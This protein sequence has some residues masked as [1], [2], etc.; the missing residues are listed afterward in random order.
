MELFEWNN[1][2]YGLV[3]MS[4]KTT[5]AIGLL[6]MGSLIDK[7]GTKKDFPFR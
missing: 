1:K 5:Y 6:I 2:Y 7:L 4:C 3:N